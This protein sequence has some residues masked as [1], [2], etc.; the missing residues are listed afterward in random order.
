MCMCHPR[1]VSHGSEGAMPP[2]TEASEEHLAA[3]AAGAEKEEE[4]GLASPEPIDT[5]HLPRA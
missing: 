5:R 3:G 2:E 1:A 4:T